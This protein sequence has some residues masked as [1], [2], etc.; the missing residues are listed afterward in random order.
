MMDLKGGS[1][2]SRSFAMAAERSLQKV[3]T[4]RTPQAVKKTIRRGKA[5][6][7][8]ATR[9]EGQLPREAGVAA[10]RAQLERLGA[11][12][13]GTGFHDVQMRVIVD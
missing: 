9:S 10:G 4:Q 7:R 3:E 12:E 13:V 5:C 6:G 11:I 8:R 1:A 2:G